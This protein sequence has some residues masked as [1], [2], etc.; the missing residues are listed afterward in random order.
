MAAKKCSACGRS[1]ANA[2]IGKSS[3][4]D[5]ARCPNCDELNQL[6]DTAPAPE[7]APEE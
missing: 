6:T 7:A 3:A 5:F 2:V 1:L 4:G